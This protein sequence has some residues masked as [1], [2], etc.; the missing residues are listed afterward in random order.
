MRGYSLVAGWSASVQSLVVQVLAMRQLGRLNP[1]HLLA[2]GYGQRWTEWCPRTIH[3]R[4]LWG[5][6]TFSAL[7]GHRTALRGRDAV[8]TWSVHH[9]R[10][11]SKKSSAS[12]AT[13]EDDEEEE[14]EGDQEESDYED[15]DPS[16]PKG[17]K[18]IEKSVPCFRYD[19]ILKSGLDM[20]R[21]KVEDA[22]YSSR[23]RLNGQKLI[24]KSK[25]VRIGDTL[26]FVV[27]EENETKKVKLMRIVVKKIL[28]ES[29]REKQKVSLRR[30][31]NLELS[32]D[33]AFRS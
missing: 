5:C 8:K 11:K 19:V 22:F 33:E 30:W 26:D 3:I 25:T 13:Q 31:K 14:E 17:Y 16:V 24:K 15:E 18:D 4:Q 23:L 20:A 10:F 7:G 29:D 28:V 2:A 9:L 12:R 27:S 1:R 21:N 32:K 6:S